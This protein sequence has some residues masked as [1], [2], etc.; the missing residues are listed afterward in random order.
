MTT[1]TDEAKLTSL[2]LRPEVYDLW[3]R[4]AKHMG[5]KKAQVFSVALH[6]L[7]RREGVPVELKKESVNA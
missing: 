1:P 7:A 4:V 3:E 5:L 6:E 2:R